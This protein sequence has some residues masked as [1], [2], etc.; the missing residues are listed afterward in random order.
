[1]NI[2]LFSFSHR[3]FCFVVEIVGVCRSLF[4]FRLFPS[5]CLTKDVKI[6]LIVKTIHFLTHFSK[7]S[8]IA[9]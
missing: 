2:K 8:L 4:F 5:K 7:H 1:M 9:S 3:A 6:F